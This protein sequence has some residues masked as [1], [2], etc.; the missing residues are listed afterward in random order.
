M[1]AEA[2]REGQERIVVTNEEG[3]VEEEEES[4]ERAAVGDTVNAEVT[5]EID[6]KH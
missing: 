5:G 3:D 4:S 1:A 2:A 6:S